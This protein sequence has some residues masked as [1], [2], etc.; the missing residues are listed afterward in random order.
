MDNEIKEEKNNN[1]NINNSKW[2]K[3]KYL[4]QDKTSFESS[5]KLLKEKTIKQFTSKCCEIYKEKV[6]IHLLSDKNK[7]IF[8]SW[9]N[10]KIKNKDIPDYLPNAVVKKDLSD[11]CEDS[12]IKDF[13]FYFRENNQYML[14]LIQFLNKEKRKLL[15]PFLCHFFYENFFMENPEQEEILYIIYLLLEKEVDELLSP[16]LFS[17]LEDS[18]LGEF[19]IEIGNK[20]D[21]K[22]YIDISLNCLIREVEEKSSFYNSMD[23]INNSKLHYQ[24]YNDKTTFFDMNKQEN[25]FPSDESKIK[26]LNISRDIKEMSSLFLLDANINSI[27]DD[28]NTSDYR[29]R[30][31]TTVNRQPSN[32]NDLNKYYKN[33]TVPN[34]KY[35]NSSIKNAI[36]NNFFSN[37]DENFLLKQMEIEKDENKKRFYLK[38]IKEIKSYNN[39]NFFNCHDYYQ[40]MKETKYISRLSVENFN[41]IYEIITNFI[42]KLFNNLENKIITPYLV[43]AI[44]KL[45]YVLIQKKFKNI[46]KMNCN[47]LICRFLFDKLILPVLENPDINNASTKMIISLNTRKI[48]A[49]INIV[50]KKIIRGEFF[51]SEENR[52]YN[53]FNKFIL[54]NYFRIDKIISNIIEVKI[55]DKLT[56]LSNQFYKDEDFCLDKI[57][58]QKEKINYNYFDENPN[59]FMMHKSICFNINQFLLLYGA[60][61][62]N[63]E[64]FIKNNDNFEKIL[65]NI[66]KNFGSMKCA[67]FDYYVIINED[68]N[69]D[70]KEL[71]F[72]KEKKITLSKPENQ[73]DALFK[74]KYSISYLFSH[75]NILYNWNWINKNNTRNIFKFIHE[76][77]TCY[78]EKNE[79]KLPPLNWYTQFIINNLDK[80]NKKYIS[81]DYELL[82]KEIED[83]IKDLLHKLKKLNEFLTVNITT[84][85][86]LIKN[87]KNNFKKELESVK[88]TELNIKT[89]LFMES[90]DTKEL[91]ICFINGFE[92][93][94]L[95][96][97]EEEKPVNN[98]SLIICRQRNCPHTRISFQIE[99]TPY[100]IRKIKFFLSNFHCKTIID[101]AKIFCNYHKFISEEIQSYSMGPEFY[102]SKES[103]FGDFNDNNLINKKMFVSNSPKKILEIYMKLVKKELNSNPIFNYSVSPQTNGFEVVGSENMINDSIK[104]SKEDQDKVLNLIWNYI[105]KS[106]IN[107]IYSIEPILVDQSFNL[108]CISLNSYVKP[109]NLHIPL[110]IVNENILNKVRYHIERIDELRTPGGM[111]EE[112]GVV[113]SLINSLYIFFLNQSQIEAGDL[114]PLIIYCIISVKPKRIIFNTNFSKFFLNENEILGGIGYNVIQ[115]ES[116]INFIKNLEAKQLGVSQEEF[117]KYFSNSTDKK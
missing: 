28:N 52:Y 58:R 42:D 76:Y 18:F 19:L 29:K 72:L 50:L 93:N 43:K 99:N 86:N 104:L 39:K 51:N 10:N 61:H 77:L 59:D 40:K 115:A 96:K 41:F 35:E 44:C 21:V 24:Y 83:D 102:K 36:N 82:Y 60:V 1:D 85:F 113:V 2:L 103:L 34:I 73:K 63:K 91:K 110:E 9:K 109:E 89:F 66:T 111:I 101:F 87:K 3:L 13:L 26:E 108:R 30:K 67:S 8:A 54:D 69:N 71:L 47:T 65:S 7:Q 88:R 112:I 15:I 92:Y 4:L 74:L 14:K 37:I 55:P 49:H 117:N 84:K 53:A 16:S 31:I 78:G 90:N 81:N 56:I 57:V 33:R 5:V 12:S 100:N 62:V 25:F 107:K 106:L 6:Q 80:I 94:K 98:N 32:F 75:V 38:Q 105:L 11:L 116:S 46:S 95:P 45:I 70:V 64:Y 23:I 114:L 22:N 20:Y 48:L 97:N 68:Y 79:K 17:F 27:N